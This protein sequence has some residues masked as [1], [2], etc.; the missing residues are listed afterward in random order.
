V[1]FERVGLGGYKQ[2]ALSWMFRCSKLLWPLLLH[3][4]ILRVLRRYGITAGQAS[5]CSLGP[6]FGP[7]EN[8]LE[9]KLDSRSNTA[10]E[11]FA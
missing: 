9:E 6:Q 8:L 3:V 2:A 1:E 5:L 11:R 10:V 7:Q 4:S